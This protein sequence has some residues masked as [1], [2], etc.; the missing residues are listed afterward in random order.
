MEIEENIEKIVEKD[1]PTDK[2]IK[3]KQ[4]QKL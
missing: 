1:A 2:K 4:N 3:P